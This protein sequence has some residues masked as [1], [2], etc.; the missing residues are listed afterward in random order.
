MLGPYACGRL[1]RGALR[2]LL[3]V[4]IFLALGHCAA[5]HALPGP[6]VASVAAGPFVMGSDEA[7]RD[8]AYALDE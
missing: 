7:E 4:P 6:E 2:R 5:P 3:P 8:A 1:Q